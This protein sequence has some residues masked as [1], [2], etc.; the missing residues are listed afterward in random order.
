MMAFF[1]SVDLFQSLKSESFTLKWNSEDPGGMVADP[2]HV[3]ALNSRAN[4]ENNFSAI[5]YDV[6]RPKGYKP[7]DYSYFSGIRIIL[8]QIFVNKSMLFQL[9]IGNKVLSM[10]TFL[11]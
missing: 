7:S 11:V 10:S 2:I 9:P 5:C 8:P 1:L 6:T 4:P 3:S